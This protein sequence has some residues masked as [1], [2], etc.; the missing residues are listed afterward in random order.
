MSLGWKFHPRAF[1]LTLQLRE[2]RNETW[3]EV[4]LLLVLL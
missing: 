4:S 1:D 3:S 2:N